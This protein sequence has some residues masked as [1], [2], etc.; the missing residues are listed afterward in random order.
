MFRYLEA[1]G[2]LD[3]DTETIRA[4]KAH[5]RREY[6]THH[7]QAY[8]K[9]TMSHTITCKP[10][11]EKV[12]SVAAR[13]HGMSV[14]EY[15]RMAALAYTGKKFLVPRSDA[16]VELKQQLI[17]LRTQIARL[18]N[19]K[20]GLFRR[21]RSEQIETLLE[22]FAFTFRTAFQEP[23]DLEA[24]IRE[25]VSTSPEFLNVLQA[26]LISHDYQVHRAKE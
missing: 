19:E 12:F 14:A 17:F 3:K 21:D 7:K 2:L 16:L 8:R 26:I 22:S 23:K 13:E 11:E 15:V 24:V 18:G 1:Q 20:Q 25:T 9:R 6:L 10:I 4:G 5:Y